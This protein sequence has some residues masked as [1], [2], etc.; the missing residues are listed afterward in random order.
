[1]SGPGEEW[2]APS[3]P[4][5]EQQE[6]PATPTPEAGEA[7]RP[8]EPA[9]ALPPT[10][11]DDATGLL[12]VSPE[13][14]GATPLPLS[15]V[16][17]EPGEDTPAETNGLA[18]TGTDRTGLAAYT[19]GQVS[20]PYTGA[21]GASAYGTGVSTNPY[22]GQAYPEGGS[23][24][25]D[26]APDLAK[27]V[28]Y[29]P[30]QAVTPYAPPSPVVAGVSSTTPSY[31]Q[32]APVDPDIQSDD[33]DDE[34]P[35]PA[36]GQGITHYGFPA[37]LIFGAPPTPQFAP[38]PESAYPPGSPDAGTS[39]SPTLDVG[40]SPPV[41]PP[42]P[43]V[44]LPPAPGDGTAVAAAL[45]GGPSPPVTPMPP[46]A[47]SPTNADGGPP[48]SPAVDVNPSAPVVAGPPAFTPA[49][50]RFAVPRVGRVHAAVSPAGVAVG[51]GGI[52]GPTAPRAH[53]A[54]GLGRSEIS[55]MMRMLSGENY[56]KPSPAGAND[57][58]NPRSSDLSNAVPS[59]LSHVRAPDYITLDVSWGSPIVVAGGF[60]VTY[61]R[62]GHLF[63]GP[64]VGA[65]TPG[66]SA[67][68]R[69]GWILQPSSSPGPQVDDFVRHWSITLSGFAHIDRG[70][71]PAVAATWGNVGD[72]HLS[73]FGAELGGALGEGHS[74]ALQVSYTWQLPLQ[75]P[76]W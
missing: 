24:R 67:A 35:V 43:P 12:S 60:Q 10:T 72:T 74:V 42:P 54:P 59:I 38:L 25:V 31:V 11:P 18:T 1:M 50:T 70:A 30:Q 2:P 39:A 17:Y 16:S 27:P 73:D 7:A 14:P 29:Y 26:L 5:P 47:A 23:D 71:G 3:E 15:A 22:T 19:G 33:G 44:F 66:A 37:Q 62:S 32:A 49:P 41:A 51:H 58:V 8:P 68:L 55:R 76:A 63:V 56:S 34:A 52:Y 6:A 65:S 4:T 21:Q 28:P 48:A 57:E 9:S 45:S 69:S 20:N 46:A 40:P 75:G 61:T 13:L 36:A 53:A 64:E